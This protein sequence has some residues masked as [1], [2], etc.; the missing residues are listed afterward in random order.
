MS[1]RCQDVIRNNLRQDLVIK[2]IFQS[3]SAKR[4]LVLKSVIIELLGKTLLLEKLIVE[5]LNLY[6][7]QLFVASELSIA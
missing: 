7:L 6:V 3:T 4:L 1:E 2:S 5:K